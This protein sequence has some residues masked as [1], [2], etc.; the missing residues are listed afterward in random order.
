MRPTRSFARL[1]QTVQCR[2]R[3]SPIGTS[4]RHWLAAATIAVALLSACASPAPT[5]TPPPAPTK[6]AA[7]AASAATPASTPAS[8]T[9]PS[10]AATTATKPAA[11]TPAASGAAPTTASTSA[12][13]AAK[14]AAAT[15]DPRRFAIVPDQSEVTL[16]VQEQ[17]ADRAVSN[18]AVLTS[19][20]IAGHILID[21][22][23]KVVSDGSKFTVDLA[24]LQSDRA[25]RDR[26]IKGNTLEVSKFPSA[27]FVP[28]EIR[29]LAN[30]A[31]TSG[32]VKGQ[33][34][35]NMTIHGVTRP[36]TFELDGNLEGGTFKG[37]ATSQF[38]ITDFGMSLPRVPVIASIEDLARLQI[39]VTATTSAT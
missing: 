29:G 39:D 23:G 3:R 24:S 35:G 31:A 13:T 11:S 15:A 27:E 8:T 12:P 22:A 26:F 37:T 6:P 32:P 14:P 16:K 2:G 25:T 17:F 19:R 30:P 10:P 18:D 36:V 21:R 20:A 5:V 38:K 4:P 7:T 34:L 33:L 9:A 28:T 1:G